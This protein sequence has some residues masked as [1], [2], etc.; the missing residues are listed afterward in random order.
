MG[1][2][3][4]KQKKSEKFKYYT[5]IT[6]E[7]FDNIFKYRAMSLPKKCH[8]KISF[9]DQLLLTLIKLR[10]DIQFENLADQFGLAKSSC[11]DILEGG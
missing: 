7:T 1:Y 11:H 9:E 6:C 4:L 10:L 2:N 3:N 5:S 8:S